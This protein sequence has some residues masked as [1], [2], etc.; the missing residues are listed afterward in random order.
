MGGSST[1][2][3]FEQMGDTGQKT[4]PIDLYLVSVEATLEGA[5]AI[6]GAAQGREGQQ[7]QIVA[8]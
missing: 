3:L 8:A 7:R 6:A 1:R 4:F 5:L 2:R